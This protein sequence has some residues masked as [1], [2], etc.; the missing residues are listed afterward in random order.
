[1]NSF[2]FIVLI[3]SIIRLL[4]TLLIN[5][6]TIETRTSQYYICLFQSINLETINHSNYIVNGYPFSYVTLTSSNPVWGQCQPLT[7]ISVKLSL[8]QTPFSETLKSK[9]NNFSLRFLCSPYRSVNNLKHCE[10]IHFSK[11]KQR[12]FS[13]KELVTFVNY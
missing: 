2:Y 12:I 10:S 5:V 11:V 8:A 9:P 1:M 3:S 13:H 6:P 4:N 7:M